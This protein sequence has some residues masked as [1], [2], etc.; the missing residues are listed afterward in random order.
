LGYWTLAGVQEL[1]RIGMQ[2][3]NKNQSWSGKS[4]ALTNPAI[5]QL[6]NSSQ[7]L[8]RSQLAVQALEKTEKEEESESVN[9]P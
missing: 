7:C 2:D 4:C 3:F 6:L 1:K 5:L 8:R 9:D